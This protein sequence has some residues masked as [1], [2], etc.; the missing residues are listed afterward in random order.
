MTVDE[1]V[2]GDDIQEGGVC[3]L[4]AI[5]F[6]IARKAFLHDVTGKVIVS[7]ASHQ[8]CKNP[9]SMPP[10]EFPEFTHARSLLCKEVVKVTVRRQIKSK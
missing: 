8:V 10:V 4:F 9:V 7:C 1:R 3:L 6:K 5:L 2:S